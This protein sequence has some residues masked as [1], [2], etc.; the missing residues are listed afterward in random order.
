CRD[1]ERGARARAEVVKVATGPAPELLLAD[2]SSLSAVRTLAHD[3][4]RRFAAID[5]LINNAGAI[6]AHREL[7]ADGIEKT[8]ATNHL[9]PFLLTNLLLDL[10]CV[11]TGGRIV[12]VTA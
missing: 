7:T 8:F 5:V 1:P 12:N 6:F 4:R 11:G 10:V 9:G 2:I 3:V